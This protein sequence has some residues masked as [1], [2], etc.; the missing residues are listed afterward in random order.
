[1]HDN[2]DFSKGIDFSPLEEIGVGREEALKLLAALTPFAD[3]EIKAKIRSEFTNEEWEDI[4]KEGV[5]RG[6]PP[7][8]GMFLIEEKY[9]AKTGNYFMEE[10]R[11]LLNKY[12]GIL[13]D[14]VR[15]ARQ[16]L[17]VV[18]E[19]DVSEQTKLAKLLEEKKW[20]EAAN[21]FEN[22]LKKGQKYA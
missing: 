18:S 15:R 5:K 10:M 17:K 20:E 19:A 22:I 14:T 12:V 9:H 1:M 4:G 16:D 2:I 6:L 8:E 7:E 13:A 3:L 11:L 21:L